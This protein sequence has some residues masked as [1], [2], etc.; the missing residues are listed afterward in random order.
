[1]HGDPKRPASGEEADARRGD[2]FAGLDDRL[3]RTRLFAGLA[4]IVAQLGGVREAHAAA[5]LAVAFDGVHDFILDHGI[6][7]PGKRCAGHDAH[8]LAVRDGAFVGGAGRH[9][10]D[11]VELDGR[12]G[13][14]RGHVFPAHGEAVHRGMRERADVDI[15]CDPLGCDASDGIEQIDLLGVEPARMRAGEGARVFEGDHRGYVSCHGVPSLCE[16]Y[17]ARDRRLRLDGA[18]TAYADFN[19]RG[20]PVRPLWPPAFPSSA[21][22]LVPDARREARGRACSM[23]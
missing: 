13:A 10:G 17:A 21:R 1:M 4:D 23:R 16:S 14:C 3:A 18:T 9:V 5:C 8:A 22:P 12:F 6:R 11:H 2:D 20:D 7:I 19:R 15:A